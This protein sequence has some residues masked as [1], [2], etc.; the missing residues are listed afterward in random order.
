VIIQTIQKVKIFSPYSIKR[1]F[2]RIL[3]FTIL[4]SATNNYVSADENNLEDFFCDVSKARLLEEDVISL[5]F[6]DKNFNQAINKIDKKLNNKK[7]N[8]LV[9]SGGKPSSGYSLEF[10]KIKKKKK[11]DKIYF[12]EIKPKKNSKNL[13]VITYPFCLVKIENLNEFKVKI[14]KKRLKF[15][16]FSVS[17]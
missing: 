13:A 4:I 16:P 5:S 9:S 15:F 14:K 1:I 3:F 12:E 6:K 11:F 10:L 7:Y 17:N 8:L 2:K